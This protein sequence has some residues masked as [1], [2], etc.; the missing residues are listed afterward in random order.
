MMPSSDNSYDENPPKPTHRLLDTA[1][2][3]GQDSTCDKSDH[4]SATVQITGLNFGYICLKLQN[5][6]FFLF[7]GLSPTPIRSCY[8]HRRT[9]S[10]TN[11][12]VE[13]PSNLVKVVEVYAAHDIL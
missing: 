6:I 5:C 7:L 2:P 13:K 10:A 1:I 3:I 12:P 4:G 9:H 8:S 11:F